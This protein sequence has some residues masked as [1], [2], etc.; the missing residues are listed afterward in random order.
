MVPFLIIYGTFFANV[1]LSLIHRHTGRKLK[2]GWG[3]LRAWGWGMCMH[4]AVKTKTSKPPLSSPVPSTHTSQMTAITQIRHRSPQSCRQ[5]R[6]ETG[7]DHIAWH[8]PPTHMFPAYLHHG[9]SDTDNRHQ[10]Y[11]HHWPW[12]C[13]TLTLSS[14]WNTYGYTLAQ[15]QLH[16]HTQLHIQTHVISSVHAPRNGL[17]QDSPWASCGRR[18]RKGQCEG[19]DWAEGRRAY[20]QTLF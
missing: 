3:Q 19:S 13:A 2:Q 10:S 1:S 20:P 15:A 14:H 4:T 5:H 18:W 16:M 6:S 12:E 9:Q 8:M 11:H 7:P 17:R